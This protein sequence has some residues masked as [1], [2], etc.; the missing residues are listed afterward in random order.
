MTLVLTLGLPRI[1]AS[2]AAPI[3]QSTSSRSVKTFCRLIQ[4]AVKLPFLSP[5]S[6]HRG[7]IG[8]QNEV[9]IVAIFNDAMRSENVNILNLCK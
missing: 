7:I 1:S 4:G 6:C 8:L 5:F 3:W 9:S 2:V